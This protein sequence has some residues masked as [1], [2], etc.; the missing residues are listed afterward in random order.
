MTSRNWRTVTAS[1][2]LMLT[3]TPA[4]AVTAVPEPAT[5]AII[6]VGLAGIVLFSRRKK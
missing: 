6:G 4:L 3:A 2:I 1:A 5:L